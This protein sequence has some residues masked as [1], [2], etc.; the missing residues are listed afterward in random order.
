MDDLAK[1]V[2]EQLILMPDLERYL[3]IMSKVKLTDLERQVCDMK[4]L[5]GL[6][7]IT[8]GEELGYS[9]SYMKRI[10]QRILRKITRIF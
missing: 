6:T 9:E 8:I 2:R 4:Y 3:D 10:H 7:L 5:R 1:S